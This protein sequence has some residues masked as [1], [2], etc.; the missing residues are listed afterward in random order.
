MQMKKKTPRKRREAKQTGEELKN[1]NRNSWV[2][3][4]LTESVLISNEEK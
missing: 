4:K 3:E 2:D 1:T